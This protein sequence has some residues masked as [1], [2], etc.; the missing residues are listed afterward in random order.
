[1]Q[2]ILRPSTMSQRD[3]DS[4]VAINNSCNLLAWD[5][6]GLNDGECYQLSDVHRTTVT[7][8]TSVLFHLS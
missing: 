8:I 7:S 5:T 2:I 4:V 6:A 1:M 3:S